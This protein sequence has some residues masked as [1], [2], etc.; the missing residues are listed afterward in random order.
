M[1]L[2]KKALAVMMAA[3]SVSA[4]SDLDSLGFVAGLFGILSL[5]LS[6]R[7]IYAK[8]GFDAQIML[9]SA[10]LRKLKEEVEKYE[11]D[12]R[13]RRKDASLDMDSRVSMEMHKAKEASD[14]AKCRF[15]GLDKNYW[16]RI[17]V[18]GQS[19]SSSTD[20]QKL[21]DDKA[22]V[23][24][25]IAM[26]KSKYLEMDKKSFDNIM[27]GYQRKQIEIDAKIKAIGGG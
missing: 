16:N 3:S 26:T 11:A 6:Y 10:Q 18:M 2:K 14:E 1:D 21:K 20:L 22:D 25:M 7:L 17:G 12:V 13:R 24:R 27:E 19:A 9:K 5:I 4:Q 15:D 23:E 8:N